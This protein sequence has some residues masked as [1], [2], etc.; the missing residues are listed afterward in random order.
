MLPHFATKEEE[1]KEKGSLAV[2]TSFTSKQPNALESK[3][4]YDKGPTRSRLFK[5][6]YKSGERINDHKLHIKGQTT[7]KEKHLKTHPTYQKFSGNSETD[8][9]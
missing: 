9:T 4:T 1:E 7:P 8:K 5:C 3:S 2:L 6:G